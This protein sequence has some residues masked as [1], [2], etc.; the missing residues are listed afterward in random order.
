M[1]GEVMLGAANFAFD[2]PADGRLISISSNTALY[3]VL[4]ARYGGNGTTDFALP[5]L[6]GVTPKSANG[7]PLIYTICAYGIYPTQS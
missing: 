6:R 1:V 7:V 2:L 4:G 3:G 5:D